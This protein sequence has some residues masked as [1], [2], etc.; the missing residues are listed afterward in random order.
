VV[1]DLCSYEDAEIVKDLYLE[2]LRDG[3]PVGMADL[4]RVRIEPGSGKVTSETLGA[5]MEL[6][7][8]NYGRHNE[9]PYRYVWGVDA[10]SGWLDRIVKADVSDGTTREWSEDGCSPGE[11]VF[12]A[13]PDASAE[14]EGVLLSVVFDAGSGGS[15]LLVLDAA[16]LSELAR[17]ETPHHIPYGF[18]GQF[19][20]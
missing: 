7:R 13:A 20:R 10:Q 9:R 14:D 18:H 5:Q 17:A 19:V 12:V 8:I 3:K 2:R 11:P 1:V 15:F 6:P 16:D 4:R